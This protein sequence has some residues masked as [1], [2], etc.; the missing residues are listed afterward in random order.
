MGSMSIEILRALALAR[1]S[2][3]KF[4]ITLCLDDEVAQIYREACDELTRLESAGKEETKPKTRRMSDK[5]VDPVEE[6]RAYV[7]ELESGLPVDATLQVNFSPV[8]PDRYEALLAMY[9]DQ[10]GNVDFR[11]FYPALL[12]ECYK[13]ATDIAGEDLKLSW[14]EVRENTLTGQDYDNCIA[15]CVALHRSTQSIPFG[16]ANSGRAGQN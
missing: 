5:A 8:S 1:N 6:Q 4:T 15:G 9:A 12:E 13:N 10:R 16:Q 11:S 3:R 14:D 7:A 2:E